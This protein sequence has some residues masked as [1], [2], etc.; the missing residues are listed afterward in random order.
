MP[1]VSKIAKLPPALR[2]WLHKAFVER[3]FGS[4]EAI[5]QELNDMLK[6]QGLQESV[7]KTS[8]GIESQR[9]R[10]AQE[11]LRASI[12]AA[13]LLQQDIG[14]GDALGGAT[15]DLVQNEVF[16]L[17]LKARELANEMDPGE[18]IDLV[19]DLALA[20][21][22]LSRSRVN[23]DKWAQDVRAKAQAA[24]EK[25]QDMAKKGG[26]SD[27]TAKAMYNLINGIGN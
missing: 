2:E 19:N 9:V 1:P 3:S 6:A 21:S 17:T 23:Q 11:S 4:I 20:A 18:R 15:L 5:T 22:R 14:A 13:R 12:E 24:A 16:Q 26:L 10:A 7:S 8:V 25:V 27:A